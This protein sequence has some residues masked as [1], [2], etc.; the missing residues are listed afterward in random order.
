MFAVYNR[1]SR[2]QQELFFLFQRGVSAIGKMP[3]CSFVFIKQPHVRCDG[4]DKG[5]SSKR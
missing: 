2:R 5:M 3:Y 4:E 1:L